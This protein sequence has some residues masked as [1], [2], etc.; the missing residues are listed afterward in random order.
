MEFFFVPVILFITVVMP[1]WIVFHYITLWKRE[2][3]AAR[4]SH[5][6]HDDLEQLAVRLEQRLESIE[7]IL[8]SDAPQWRSRS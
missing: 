6:Q 7:S 3:R 4:G 1:L 8:D 5:Q 2:R